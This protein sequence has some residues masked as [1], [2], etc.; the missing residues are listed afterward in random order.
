M[1][2]KAGL[3]GDAETRISDICAIWQK[4][5]ISDISSDTAIWIRSCDARYCVSDAGD[6]ILC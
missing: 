2:L 6:A 1:E 3:G 5:C 4:S